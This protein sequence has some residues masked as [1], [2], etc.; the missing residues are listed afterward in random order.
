MLIV[1]VFL[2]LLVLLFGAPLVLL[3]GA[4]GAA[5]IIGVCYAHPWLLAFGALFV[6]SVLLKGLAKSLTAI[7]PR[8]AQV[9]APVAVAPTAPAQPRPSAFARPR[10]PMNFSNPMKPGI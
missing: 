2:I 8:Q 9:Q 10:K 3:G 7:A 5:G 4:A 1:L 6:L